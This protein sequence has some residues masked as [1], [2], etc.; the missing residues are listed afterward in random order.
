[1]SSAPPG[2]QPTMPPAG[3][4]NLTPGLSMARRSRRRL[5]LGLSALAATGLGL[6]IWQRLQPVRVAVGVDRPLVYGAAIDPTDLNTAQHYLEQ[7]QDSP[8]RLETMFNSAD[9]RQ[10]RAD[11]KAVRDQGVRFIINTQ[12]SSHAT[13]TLDLYDDGQVLAI[14]VSATSTALSGRDDHFLRIIPDLAQEQRAIAARINQMAGKRLLVMRDTRN[15]RYTEPALAQFLQALQAERDWQVT[16]RSFRTDRFDPR[17]ERSV[18]SQ[19]YDVLYILGGD[20]LPTMGNL[21][22][23]FHLANPTAPIMLTPWANSPA[24]LENAGDAR[25]MILIASPYPN[26]RTKPA[27]ARY[28]SSHEERFGYQPYAMGVGTRQAIE[29]LDQAFRRG[30]RTPSAVKRYLLTGQPHRTSLGPIQFNSSGDVNSTY[31]FL[32]P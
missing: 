29:L 23:Q 9:P 25:Q 26:R 17:R 19:P 4:R 28:F 24:V 2:R 8:I 16:V 18:V 1:M 22:Q 20:F 27:L 14:N 5:A 10:G 6:G 12:T 3:D 32:R 31:H 11:L 30:H 15:F 7:N 21:A 13:P